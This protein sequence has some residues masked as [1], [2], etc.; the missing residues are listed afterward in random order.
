MTLKEK[1]FEDLKS[2]MKSKDTV[3]KECIQMV[4][5]GILQI[6]KDQKIEVDDDGVIAVINKE[7]K[8]YSDVL[9]DFIRGG[10]QDLADQVN[11]KIDILKAYLPEQLSEEAIQ[12]IIDKVI[13]QVG[14]VSIRDMGKVMGAVIAETKGAADNKVVSRL[15]KS[16]L[17]KI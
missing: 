1:L 12:T 17:Q 13:S 5:A 3:A 2:A 11:R 14:A 6:E 16:A 7:I 4:R 8:K 15:V 10:R 9:P